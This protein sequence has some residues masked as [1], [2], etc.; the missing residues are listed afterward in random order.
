MQLFLKKNLVINIRKTYNVSWKQNIHHKKLIMLAETKHT[1]YIYFMLYK[2][3]VIRN[4]NKNSSKST[5][6]NSRLVVA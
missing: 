2:F 3:S 4:L 1:S 6:T 5:K